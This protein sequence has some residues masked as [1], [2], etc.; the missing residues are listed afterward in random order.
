MASILRSLANL[1]GRTVVPATDVASVIPLTERDRLIATARDWGYFGGSIKARRDL[2][3][4]RSILDVGMGGGPHAVAF[5]AGGAAA[6]V[7]V[8]PL[9]GTDHVRDFRNVKDPSIPAYH[10]FPFTTADI[11]RLLPG[12][13]LYPG[14]LEN[15]A[16]QVRSHGLDFA[17]MDA[18]TEHLERPHEVVRAI[19]E[20]LAPGGQ[21]W[22]CHCNYYSWTG[23]HRLPRSVKQWDQADAEQAEHVDWR[24][25]EP[26]HPDYSNRN[27]NRIRLADLQA[28][29]ETYFEIVDWRIAVA[30]V[31]R[32]TPEIRARWKIY[33]L[34][35][36]L[37]Q[38]IYIT[39]RRRDVPLQRDLSGLEL[40][41]PSAGYRA[42]TDHSGEDMEPYTLA[43]TLSF[44]KKGQ[45][46]SGSDNDSGGLRVFARLKRGD[47]ITLK[48][49]TWTLRVTVAAVAPSKDGTLRVTL[50]E[51]MPPDIIE[52]SRDDWTIVE[53]GP[54]PT[55]ATT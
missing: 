51:R 30:A 32:L 29:I 41:H 42:N 5:M 53:Y 44:T 46:A 52:Q 38:N 55:V 13:H 31:S 2:W 49:F 18:V 7:G 50:V 43:H 11:M 40:H 21:L 33:T 27:Y 45:L 15:V 37:G 36:L 23:H 54:R 6:Y 35:E 34:A 1:V 3:A 4:E 14:T 20:L 24:H 9:V 12:V 48:K 10:A 8:D 25:L 19:W 26:T 28:V 16:D 39:A 47:V 22:L 17:V